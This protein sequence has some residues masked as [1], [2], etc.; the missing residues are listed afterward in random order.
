MMKNLLFITFA[1][2]SSFLFAQ[3]CVVNTNQAP[4]IDDPDGAYSMQLDGNTINNDE[5]SFVAELDTLTALPHA[6]TGEIFSTSVG[7]RIPADT[8]LVYDLGSGPQL[9]E[10]VEIT[11]ISITSI[12]GLPMGFDFSCDNTECNWAGGDYGCASLYTINPVDPVLSG[13]GIQAYPL[14]FI[15]TVDANYSLFGIPVPLTDIVV[16]DLLDYYVLVVEESNNSSINDIIDSRQFAYLGTTPNPAT[17]NCTIQY[18]NDEN[19]IIDFKLFDVLGNLV[20]SNTYQSKV[21]YNQ[22]DLD[23]NHFDS[24]IYTFI[25]SNDYNNITKRIIVK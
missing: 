15:L 16:D 8:S 12:D 21:G 14:N 13:G 17:S 6:L 25:M 24:G 3:D 11:S 23:L 9:F 4:F 10:G 20:F 1:L 19:S 2:A 18:G 5:L 7:V 22:I